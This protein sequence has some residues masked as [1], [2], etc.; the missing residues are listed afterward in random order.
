[1]AN[2]THDWLTLEQAAE[3]FGYSHPENLRQRLRELR[4]RG[5]VVDIGSPPPEYKVGDAKTY[6]KIVIF[7]PNAK[8]ARGKR[9]LGA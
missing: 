5:K 2:I 8:T 4:K 7:W 9:R 6:E 1:M 3:H